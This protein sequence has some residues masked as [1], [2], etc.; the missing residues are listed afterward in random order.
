MSADI[1]QEETKVVSSVSLE[2]ITEDVPLVEFMYLV[3]TRMTGE[4][5]RMRLRSFCYCV[6]VTSF[7]R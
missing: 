6:C 1:S 2:V 7:E 3:F 4:I 5:Y